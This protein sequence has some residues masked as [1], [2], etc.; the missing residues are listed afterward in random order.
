MDTLQQKPFR[1]SLVGD[2]CEDV[3]QYGTVDRISPEAPVP[4]FSYLRSETKPGMAGNVLLN[5]RALGCDVN[6]YPGSFSTKTRLIDTKSGH[7]IARIDY[8]N[9]IRAYDDVDPD[10]IDYEVD[11]I[12]ISD[13]NKGTVT[14]E[15]YKEIR[16]RFSKQIFVDTKQ[17]DLSIFTHPATIV[18]INEL[19]YNRRTNDTFNLI[20]TR[21][22]ESTMLI[23]AGSIKYFDVPKVRVFDVC[24]AGDTFLAS[25]VYSSLKDR[26]LFSAIDFANKASGIT[27][28]HLGVYAPT[29][30]EIYET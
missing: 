10:T 1:I 30:K 14:P 29:L 24:G 20:V 23:S 8:D 15:L 26:S 12:V 2:N 25:L 16:S 5:L 19:E 9:N 13:Y 3:Y 11:V 4:V 21:G 27:V 17:T 18:K 28:Q 6:F 7:H 22:G